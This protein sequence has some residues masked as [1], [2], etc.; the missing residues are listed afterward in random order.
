MFAITNIN[1]AHSV[2]T[3]ILHSFSLARP[4]YCLLS[5]LANNNNNNNNIAIAIVA[6]A[7]II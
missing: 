4:G 6:I 5:Q 1:L 7:I 2:K 3:P